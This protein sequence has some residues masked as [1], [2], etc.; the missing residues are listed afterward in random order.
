MLASRTKFLLPTFY[1]FFSESF[2]KT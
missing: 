2:Q 1:V